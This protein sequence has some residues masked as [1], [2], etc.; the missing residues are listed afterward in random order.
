M[1]LIV[2]AHLVPSDENNQKKNNECIYWLTTFLSSFYEGTVV[3]KAWTHPTG[4]LGYSSNRN[5]KTFH[6]SL[7]ETEE[8]P[9]LQ[10]FGNKLYSTLLMQNNIALPESYHT[11]HVLNSINSLFPLIGKFRNVA[12]HDHSCI[13]R[14]FRL[15]V[16]S[17]TRAVL[18]SRIKKVPLTTECMRGHH[19]EPIRGI[20][21]I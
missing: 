10:P 3:G 9:L 4:S 16:F 18:H 14:A 20:L 13:S 19:N 21:S 1:I 2:T 11:L 6:C 17:L 5:I 12:Q 7:P 15:S 8:I